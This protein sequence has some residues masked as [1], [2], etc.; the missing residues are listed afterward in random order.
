M[1]M[2]ADEFGECAITRINDIDGNCQSLYIE[3]ADP[4]ILISGEILEF[5]RLAGNL[6]GDMF[7]VDGT[8]CQVVYRVMKFVPVRNAWRAEVTRL[9]EPREPV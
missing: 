1:L 4:V 5:A 2:T 8:N 6:V 7:I 3:R 9:R